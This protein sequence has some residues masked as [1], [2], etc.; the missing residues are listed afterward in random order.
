[1]HNNEQKSLHDREYKF[2]I[3]LHEDSVYTSF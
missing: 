3:Y 2:F 1:M